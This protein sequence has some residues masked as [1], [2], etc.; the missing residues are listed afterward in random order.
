MA[1]EIK[2]NSGSLFTNTKKEQETHSDFQG[3]VNIEGKLYYINMWDNREKKEK[4]TQPD[5]NVK[6][7]EVRS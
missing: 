4:E 3:K 7:T 6:F 5:F 2:N 1:Y